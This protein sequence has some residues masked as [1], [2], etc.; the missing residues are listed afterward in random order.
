MKKISAN[1][2]LAYVEGENYGIELIE[3]ELRVY[4]ESNETAKLRYNQSI[5]Q[6]TEV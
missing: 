2:F 1:I 3:G 4:S 5:I 6:P